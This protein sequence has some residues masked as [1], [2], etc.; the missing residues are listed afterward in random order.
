MDIRLFKCECWVDPTAHGD[1]AST[2]ATFSIPFFESVEIGQTACERYQHAQAAEGVQVSPLLTA[3]SGDVLFTF[4][5]MHLT[6]DES[7]EPITAPPK[8]VKEVVLSNVA[9]RD[10]R[11]AAADPAQ[12]WLELDVTEA[13]HAKAEA[14]WNEHVGSL[15]VQIAPRPGGGGGMSTVCCKR[16][17]TSNPL[18]RLLPPVHPPGGT[19]DAAK[20]TKKKL[21]AAGA[22]CIVE[23][24]LTA[25]CWLQ[26]DF[27]PCSM[28]S[29]T[30]RLTALTTRSAPS[31]YSVLAFCAVTSPWCGVSQIR[32]SPL[33]VDGAQQT[34][35]FRTFFPVGNQV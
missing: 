31:S 24:P 16:L 20:A 22:R 27:S 11:T 5:R 14:S 19:E 21:G 35:K 9:R 25:G 12:P 23:L 13:P 3:S 6:G 2:E 26:A 32:C 1:G 28:S 15:E 18:S 17:A 29:S 7:S 33:L 4:T 34:L 8:A 30:A 10:T